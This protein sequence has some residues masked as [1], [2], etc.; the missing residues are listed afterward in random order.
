[1]KRYTVQ[2]TLKNLTTYLIEDKS[3]DF[4]TDTAC[5]SFT[6]ELTTNRQWKNDKNLQVVGKPTII[7]HGEN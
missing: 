1:M 2:V 3:E 5:I 4:V 6:K 7:C